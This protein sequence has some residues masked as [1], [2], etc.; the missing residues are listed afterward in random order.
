MGISPQIS[1]AGPFVYRIQPDTREYFKVF[2]PYLVSE[3]GLKRW[4]ILAIENDYGIDAAKIF[5]AM[6]TS[7][8]GTVSLS[9]TYLPNTTDFRTQLM[10]QR[11]N[12]ADGLFLISYAEMGTIL[13]QIQ[14]L[15]LPPRVAS[16]ATIENPDVIAA[17]GS[18]AEG[19]LYFHHYDP[20]ANMSSVRSYRKAYRALHGH[21]SEGF[22]MLAYESLKI[23][24]SVLS[25]CKGDTTCAQ[26]M[27]D[28]EQFEGVTGPIRFDNKGDSIR[29][30][31]VREVHDGN[32][33]TVK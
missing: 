5:S 27:L 17:A 3:Q 31:Y 7:L 10:H 32:F 24:A 14:E 30:T 25:R 15:G 19:V 20:Q 9:E 26:K 4:N 18:A 8:G 11:T 6:V 21:E 23:A 29:K 13:R 2:V 1:D 12:A 16:A 28:T 22:A 33:R